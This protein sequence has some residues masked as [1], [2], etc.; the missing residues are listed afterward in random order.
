VAGGWV[1]L[2]NEELVMVMGH[3][4]PTFRVKMEA[5]WSFETLVSYHSTIRRH[6]VVKISNLKT[7]I[8]CIDQS[9]LSRCLYR[10]ADGKK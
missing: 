9:Q 3:S 1:K 6:I 4:A 5:A 10:Y 7:N 8:F 2:L